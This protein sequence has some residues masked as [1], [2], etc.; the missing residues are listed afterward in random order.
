MLRDKSLI[1]LSHQHHNALALCVLTE[2]S[3]AADT[4][5]ANIAKLAAR[6]IDRYELEMVN[7]FELEETVL[8]PHLPPGAVEQF[9]AEHRRM[10]GLVEQLRVDPTADA[11]REFIALLRQHVRSEENDLFQR[12]QETIPRPVLDEIGEVMDRK[13][14]RICL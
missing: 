2:R 8:F 14:V 7:H 5:E 3:L 4:S 1:P 11:L 6:V 9:I 12:A 10:T 13:A